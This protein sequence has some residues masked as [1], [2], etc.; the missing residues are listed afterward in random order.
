MSCACRSLLLLSAI[1][2]GP[3]EAAVSQAAEQVSPPTTAPPA[4][5]SP[6]QLYTQAGLDALVEQAT[7]ALAEGA[8][9]RLRQPVPAVLLTAEQAL[10][11]RKAFAAT[12]PEGSGVTAGFE[13]LADFVFSQTMLGRYLPDE[14]VLYV[15]EDVVRAHVG[16][17]R[18]AR[19]FLFAIVAHELTHAHD[20]QVYGVFPDPVK[21]VERMG[22]GD[23]SELPS[24]QVTMS[25]LEGHATWASELACRAAGVTPL[26][27]PTLEDVRDAGVFE[28][29]DNPL[30]RGL[31][32]A[33]N[34]VAR[35]KLVQYVQG[36]EFCRRAMDFGGEAFMAQVF[37][38]LPLTAEE[39]ADFERFKVRWAEE[40]EAEDEV[41]E[42]AA[43]G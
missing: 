43:G 25:L 14:K 5:G 40:I 42:D 17:G 32:A 28:G 36:R 3:G 4:A 23:F 9:V 15:I 26:E 41:E 29:G 35:L 8:G 6:D 31:A 30:G 7:A 19:D 38:S 39:L 18:H 16:E 24:M 11:R 10:A 20:D 1:A 22:D 34:T 27:A 2:C 21:L 13:F 12:L 33:G 37:R